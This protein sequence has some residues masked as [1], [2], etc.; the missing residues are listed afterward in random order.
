MIEDFKHADL[1]DLEAEYLA[2]EE[3]NENIIILGGSYETLGLS[4][5]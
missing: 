5:D 2:R 1:P 3:I 4:V